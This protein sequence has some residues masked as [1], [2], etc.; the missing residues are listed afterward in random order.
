MR[1]FFSRSVMVFEG[2]A[3][4]NTATW[5]RVSTVHIELERETEE[6]EKEKTLQTHTRT[7]IRATHEHE[8]P[9]RVKTPYAR[10]GGYL[11]GYHEGLASVSFHMRA[12]IDRDVIRY[13]GCVAPTPTT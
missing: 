8:N 5:S 4:L 11:L 12:C 6:K 9:Y 3:H 1:A 2:V 13:Q 7:R 10:L